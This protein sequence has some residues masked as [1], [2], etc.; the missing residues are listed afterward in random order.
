MMNMKFSC[1]LLEFRKRLIRCLLVLLSIFFGLLYFANDIFTYLAKPLLYYLPAEHGMIATHILSPVF[2]PLELTF[3]VALF[4]TVPVMFYQCWSFVTPALYAHEKRLIWPLLFISISLF[5]VGVMFAYFVIF[6]LLFG[7]LTQ[8]APIG[9]QIAPDIA[10]YLLFSLKFLFIFGMIFEVPVIT[11]I[12]I[13][14]GVVT[15]ERFI[16]LRP[17]MI[18]AAFIMGMLLTP[19]DV[20]S[21]IMVAIPLWLLFE[22]GILLSPL[23]VRK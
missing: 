5:Y 20:V 9:V 1:Y 19:P 12:L 3:Y 23:F 16:Q 2:V 7:F 13:K 21:Q 10:E 8:S 4:C 15:R 18:V 22:L 6:P 11:I 17:Y 14:S